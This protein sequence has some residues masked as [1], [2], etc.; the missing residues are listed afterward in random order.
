MTYIKFYQQGISSNPE[1][2]ERI[3]RDKKFSDDLLS[4][5][6]YGIVKIT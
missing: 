4:L 3:R 1:I 6:M 2:N 5:F